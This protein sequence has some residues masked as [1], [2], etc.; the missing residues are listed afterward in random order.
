M[1]IRVLAVLAASL[2]VASGSLAPPGAFAQ[3]G[4]PRPLV[5]PGDALSVPMLQQQGGPAARGFLDLVGKQPFLLVYWRPGNS[6]TEQALAKAYAFGQQAAPKVPVVPIAILAA[7]QSPNEV[8]QRLAALNLKHLGTYEDNGSLGMLIGLRAI[9]SF[10]LVDAGGVV[11]VVGGSDIE[12][13]NDKGLTIA[14][15]IALAGQGAP[16]PTLGMMSSDPVFRM[17]G[18]QLPDVALTLLDGSTWRKLR[19]FLAPGKRLLVF[20]WQP[21]CPHCTALMPK[22]K[23]WYETKRPDDLLL[24]GIAR[25]DAPMLRTDANKL[26]AGYPGIQL[27]DVDRSA[28]L[29]LGVRETPTAFLVSPNG[30]VLSIRA[31]GEIDFDRWL[32]RSKS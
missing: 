13:A 2:S 6:T 5:A 19:Q 28:M 26:I 15:A 8:G 9:P 21:Q 24:V 3:G 20:Y 22:L 23:A 17:V 11:R 10:V 14:E 12:Q 16:V 25:G 29:Q 7:G 27:L 1:I 30:E 4:G 31:G 32:S 18:Q